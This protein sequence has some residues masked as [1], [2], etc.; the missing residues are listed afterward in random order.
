M[1]DSGVSKAGFVATEVLARAGVRRLYTVP[2]ESFL[3]VLDAAERHPGRDP[4]G[5]GGGKRRCDSIK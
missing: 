2:G 3:E 4:G 5:Q 1:A